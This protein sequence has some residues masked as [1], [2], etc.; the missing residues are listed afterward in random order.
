VKKKNRP[1]KMRTKQMVFNVKLNAKI[2]GDAVSRRTVQDTARERFGALLFMA[3]LVGFAGFAAEMLRRPLMWL[4]GVMPDDVFYYLHVARHLADS[5]LSTFD[6]ETLTNGYHPGWMLLMTVLARVFAGRMALLQAC[7]VT[8]F[9]LHA[10]S[11]LLLVRALRPFTSGFWPW[12]GGAFWLLN[13]LPLRVASQGMEGTLY[14]CAL[15]IV[16]CVFNERIA[17]RLRAQGGQ[18]TLPARDCIL[19]GLSLG[20]A[21][22]GRTEGL[23]LAAISLLYL[24]VAVSPGTKALSSARDALGGARAVARVWLLT[25]GSFVLC[26]APW[27]MYSLLATGSL[28][29]KSGA[30]KMLWAARDHAGVAAWQR[31]LG[32]LEFLRAWWLSVAPAILFN[33]PLGI[34]ALSGCVAMSV[35]IALGVRQRRREEAQ[36]GNAHSALMDHA[37]ATAS[38]QGATAWCQMA[39]WLLPMFLLSGVVYGAL[40]SDHRAWYW[41]QPGLVFFFLFFSGASLCWP[42]ANEADARRRRL[43]EVGGICLVAYGAAL[44]L[45]FAQNVPAVYRLQP[46]AYQ[47]LGWLRQ[48]VPPSSRVGAFNAGVP[49]YFTDIKIINLDGLMNNTVADRWRSSQFDGYLQEARIDYIADLQVSLDRARPFSRGKLPLQ[50]VGYH[51]PSQRG[52]WRVRH[53]EQ[54]YVAQPP[55]HTRPNVF[56]KR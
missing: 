42:R 28:T 46:G 40:F 34:A 20:L 9:V 53:I 16:F 17:P 31:V 54:R 13:P 23:L 22:W 26:I 25:G 43:A 15:L 21:F 52:L 3:A 8:C 19:F 47:S 7:L 6:G 14:I 51:A 2:G 41:G 33:Q 18:K 10:L 37:T 44:C 38:T 35:L 12:V 50:K 1:S 56:S 5:G 24:A 30:M 48:R 29:Q 36:N 32:T 49:A 27:L 4:L 39:A 55:Q 45:A 11:S